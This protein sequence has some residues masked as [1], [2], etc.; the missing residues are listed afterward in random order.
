MIEAVTP[1][2]LHERLEDPLKP[3]VGALKRA[4]L[5]HRVVNLHRADVIGIGL[6]LQAINAQFVEPEMTEAGLEF[7]LAGITE[8]EAV[9]LIA[10]DGMRGNPVVGEGYGFSALTAQADLRPSGNRPSKADEP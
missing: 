9:H 4:C 6:G 8:R 1:V 2:S 3:V 5:R 7:L 10:A